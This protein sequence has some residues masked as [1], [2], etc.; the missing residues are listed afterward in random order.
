MYLAIK[1]IHLTSIVLSLGFFLI[2]GVWALYYPAQLEKRWV[3]IL[4]HV[5]DTVL[6]ASAITLAVLL[7]Q[8]P[9]ID[10]WL[11]AKVIALFAYIGFG[12]MVIKRA[13]SKPVKLMAFAA[14]LVCFAYIVL[15]AINHS[16][17]PWLTT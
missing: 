14:A 13:R 16:A 10:H 15:V 3:K 1:H 4:P 7:R 17:T 12:T 5:I 9:F 11:T 2:R 6:L 8:Y